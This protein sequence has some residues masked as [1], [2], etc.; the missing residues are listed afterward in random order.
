MRFF[1]VDDDEAIRYMLSEIIEDN[2]LGEVVG[3]ADNGLAVDNNLLTLR[4]VDILIIDLL[5]PIRDGIQT[6]REIGA[7]F[8]GKII[9]FSQVENKEL[10]GEAYS[11][12]VEYYITKPINKLEVIGVIQKV[13]KHMQLQKSIHDIQKT[14]NILDFGVKKDNKED[15]FTGESITKSGEF[16]LT[17]LGMIGESGSKDLLD[18][19]QYLFQNEKEKSFENKF[20]PLKDIFINIAM[21]KLGS[22]S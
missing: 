16:L 15:T 19:L 9:M 18:M 6:V 7:S 4:K 2:D 14:L 10:I 17:E 12:G 11:L 20:P 5:M 1:I 13:I 21:K 8:N 3:E 22:S